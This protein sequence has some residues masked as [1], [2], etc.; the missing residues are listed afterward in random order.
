MASKVIIPSVLSLAVLTAVGTVHAQ[1]YL[2]QPANS[3]IYPP[4][5]PSVLVVPNGNPAAGT[6]RSAPP[7]PPVMTNQRIPGTA[8]PAGPFGVPTTIDESIAPVKLDQPNKAEA[9]KTSAEDDK[10]IEEPE[11]AAKKAA[12]KLPG[13][14]EQKESEEAKE[15][16]AAPEPEQEKQEDNPEVIQ[17]SAPPEVQVEEVPPVPEE[18]QEKAKLEAENPTAESS[19][20]GADPLGQSSQTLDN[21]NSPKADSTIDETIKQAEQEQAIDKIINQAEVYLYGDGVPVDLA[22]AAGLYARAVEMGSPKAM[23]RLSTM[24]R[25]GTGV[26]KDLNRAFTLT[27]QAAEAGYVPAMAALGFLYRDGIGIGRNETLSKHWIDKA[28]ENGH[29]FAMIMSS[30][31]LSKLTHDPDAMKKL[32]TIK[33]WLNSTVL[34]RNSI[35]SAIHTDTVCVCPE[36]LIKPWSGQRLLLTRAESTPCT[37]WVSA[38]GTDKTA[39]S[40]RLV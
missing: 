29:V 11:E 17:K 5:P 26:E 40:Y 18:E 38:T 6:L 22:K 30:E 4:P 23:M 7:V 21:L 16:E 25:R 15:K 28:A 31:Q 12:K 9:Q 1:S 36:T 39:G 13:E 14:E 34:R 33:I 37:T 27:Q 3:S 35:P 8:V 19:A 20:L 32:R 24:Y 10:D 2:S